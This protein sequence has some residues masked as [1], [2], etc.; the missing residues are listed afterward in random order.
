MSTA[1]ARKIHVRDAAL[2]AAHGVQVPWQA[3]RHPPFKFDPQTF[4]IGSEH[5]KHHFIDATVQTNS[6]DGF[7]ADPAAPCLYAVGSEPTGEKAAYF[8]AYLMAAYLKAH[9][10]SRVVWHQLWD[11]Q[12]DLVK[13]HQ[14]CSLLVISDVFP[15]MTG[16][17]MEKLR[18]LISAYSGIPIIL[19]VSG[20]DPV[21]F[22]YTQLRIKNTHLFYA[23]ASIVKRKVEVV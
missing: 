21:T 22:C 23:A 18:D 15:D 16:Y 3:L 17:R 4:A 6:L 10:H 19:I 2:F 5:L 20:T 7:L 9:P 12:A 13:Y 11:R 14:E 8:A 1:P